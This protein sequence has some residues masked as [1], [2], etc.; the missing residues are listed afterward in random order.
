MDDDPIPTDSE[1]LLAELDRIKGGLADLL[2]TLEPEELQALMLEAE[3]MLAGV[4][5]DSTARTAR[6]PWAS[7]DQGESSLIKE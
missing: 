5:F 1:S 7:L 6:P 2:A 4:E 3:A